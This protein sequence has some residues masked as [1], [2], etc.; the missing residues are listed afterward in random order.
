MNPVEG[1]LRR[2]LHTESLRIQ[3][4]GGGHNNQAFQVTAGGEFYFLKQYGND[5]VAGRKRQETEYHFLSYLQQLGTE[6]APRILAVDRDLGLALFSFVQGLPVTSIEEAD[7]EAAFQFISEINRQ[8][9]Q[10][11][12]RV[13]FGH[14]S[15]AALDTRRFVEI[16]EDR[17]QWAQVANPD[18]AIDRECQAFVNGQLIPIFEEARARL[19]QVSDWSQPCDLCF[20][21]S[22]FGF[23][24]A[25]RT[26]GGWVFLDFEYAG[27]DSVLKMTADFFAQPRWSVPIATLNKLRTSPVVAPVFQASNLFPSI[28]ELTGLKWCLILLNV[29]WRTKTDRKRFA[30]SRPLE[31]LKLEQLEKAKSYVQDLSLRV[32]QTRILLQEHRI[33]E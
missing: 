13:S 20:S 6:S 11:C 30:L 2:N 19:E 1:F 5:D 28:Y 3:R 10:D 22:D 27:V 33:R 8:F 25:L 9:T 12:G 16:V 21:P 7:V 17:L 23:H 24:N 32:E 14:A 4:L 29:F 18:D 31:A 15:E 26:P